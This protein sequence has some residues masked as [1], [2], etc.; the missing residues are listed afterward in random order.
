[1]LIIMF[2]IPFFRKIRW[3][4]VLAILSGLIY[5]TTF[6]LISYKPHSIW[7][8][9]FLLPAIFSFILLSYLLFSDYF[10]LKP[11]LFNIYLRVKSREVDDI[12]P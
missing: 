1:M 10:L 11:Y 2:T 8:T 9:L 4:G 7:D 6:I 12:E 3:L 5:T